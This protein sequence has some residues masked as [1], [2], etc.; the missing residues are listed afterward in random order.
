MTYLTAVILGLVRGITEFLPISASGHLAILQNF[1]HLGTTDEHLLFDA[2]LR[3]GAL[4]AVILGFWGE[5]KALWREGLTMLGVKKL[6]RGQKPDRLKRRTIWFLILATLPLIA[7]AFL[8]DVI[9]PLYAK[10]FFVGFAL[11]LTGGLL[12]AADRMGHG[13]KNE[14]NATLGEI[15]LVGLTQAIA[16]LP[17]LSC[18]GTTV[19]TG[20]LLGF[21]RNFAVRFSFLLLIPALLGSGFLTMIRAFGAGVNAALIPAYL[22]GTLTA[23]VSGYVSIYLLRRL[24]QRGRFGGFSYYCWG[25]GLVTLI[26]SLVA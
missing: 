2:L 8:R 26:L 24:V 22:I 12:F 17:G 7:V 19:S 9:E 25:A 20:M 13:N 4:C 6:R 23:F 18:V 16:A 1:L 3:F 5:V 14:K 15:L 10:P 11:V 21:D